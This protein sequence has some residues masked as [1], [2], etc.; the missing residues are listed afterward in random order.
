M[1]N[2]GAVN[3]SGL[4]STF[5][6]NSSPA[7]ASQDGA[8]GR[9]RFRAESEP[10]HANDRNTTRDTALPSEAIALRSKVLASNKDQEDGDRHSSRAA[11]PTR[12]TEDRGELRE[13]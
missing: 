13:L 8:F 1:P 6:T 5:A 4:G 11:E 3:A 7:S 12:L 9:T 2:G 10:G